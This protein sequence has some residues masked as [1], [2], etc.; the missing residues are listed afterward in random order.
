MFCLQAN[1][2]AKF[3]KLTNQQKKLKKLGEPKNT[4]D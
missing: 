2:L 4:S 1:K 3:V